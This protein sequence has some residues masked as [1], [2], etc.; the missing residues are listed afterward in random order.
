MQ[1]HR[2]KWDASRCSSIKEREK[3]CLNCDFSEVYSR[4][5]FPIGDS[6]TD[7]L[8]EKASA[9]RYD[10]DR[11]EDEEGE[12]DEDGKGGE[13]ADD[14][15]RPN[16]LDA[17]IAIMSNSEFV[18]RF[19]KLAVK[20]QQIVLHLLNGKGEN[21]AIHKATGWAI[22][23]IVAHRRKL[24]SDDFWGKWIDRLSAR[25]RTRRKRTAKPPALRSHDCNGEFRKQG[26]EGHR[27]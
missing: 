1:C 21:T 12:D 10:L 7:A 13:Y 27:A 5:A 3:H 20:E 8:I 25:Q 2:C 4:P 22:S 23:T 14:E 11:L 26:K 24:E 6:L 17:E 15:K 18:K 16:G 9:Q 19:P